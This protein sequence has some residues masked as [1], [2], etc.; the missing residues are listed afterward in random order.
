MAHVL[1]VLSQTDQ[2]HEAAHNA[3]QALEAR[4]TPRP[5]TDLLSTE[6][7]HLV[8]AVAAVRDNQPTNAHRYLDT[9]R[10]IA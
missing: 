1:L 7:F 2:A 8:L 6:P 10:A 5:E 4:V 9:A 3:V